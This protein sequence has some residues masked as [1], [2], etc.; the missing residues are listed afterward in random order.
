MLSEEKVMDVLEAFDLTRSYRSAAELCGVDHH[1]VH[2][3]VA[4][5]DAGLDPFGLG[6]TARGSVTD[7]FAEKI[8]EWIDRSQG[9]VRA[10]VVHTKLEALG[11]HG[12]RRTTRR[13]VAALKADWRRSHARAYRPWIPEPGLWLQWDY[14]E[15]PVVGGRRTVLFCAW[16]SWSRFRVIIALA[17]RTLPSVISAWDRCFRLLGGAP[18]YLLTDNEKTV[19][20]RHVARVPVRNPR[21]VSAAV[22]YGVSVR[23]CMPA[24]PE[25]KGGSEATV[26]IAK[27]DIVPT[28]ANLRP[29]YESFAELEAACATAMG[30]FNSRPHAVTR[31]VP[32]QMLE[33]ER[34]HL[35]AVPAE[36]YTV[37]FG[38]SRAVSWSSTVNYGGARYS[39]PHTLRDTRVWVRV[40]GE[41]VVVTS[42]GPSGAVEVARHPRQAPGGASILD[43]HYPPRRDPLERVPTATN[44]AEAAFL[45]LGEGAKLWLT[46]AAAVGTRGIEARMSEAVALA[47]VV[48]A[49][50]VDETLGLAAIAGRFAP[51]D[52][53]SILGA[54]RD[55]PRRA[56]PSVSLQPGTARWAALGLNTDDNTL[57]DRLNNDRFDDGLGA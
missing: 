57:D 33:T 9:R 41:Q 16:L 38:E 30:R 6:D 5:R 55:P 17:D 3:Y 11:Y 36:A 31:R 12:S 23:T 24:D 25:S 56:D 8:G 10:D 18:T 22:F 44:R 1:T 48:G 46:E 13:V 28:D 27:A 42:G 14:G 7:P 29:A 35:H 53:A 47:K 50:K 20:D 2:R 32:A 19:T 26:R 40:A 4:A 54:R 43:E 52:L 51:G 21:I 15:G 49:V 34:E 45:E 37:A 39:V